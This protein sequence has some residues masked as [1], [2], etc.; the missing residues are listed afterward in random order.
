MPDFR[1]ED[2]HSPDLPV[3]GIDEVGRGP[4][5]GPVVAACVYIPPEIRDMPFIR[6]LQ[7]SKKLTAIKRK[8]LDE[9]IRAHC[10]FAIAECSPAEIDRL[11][12]LQASLKAMADAFYAMPDWLHKHANS[13]VLVDGNFVPKSLQPRGVAIKK[14]DQLS[15][16]IAAA[17]IIAKVYRDA[18]MERLHRA[19]PVYGW[20]RNAGYPTAAHISALQ[21]HGITPHH[22]RSFAPIK[23][24]GASGASGAKHL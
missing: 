11:N 5:A 1:H 22:R 17:S 16:S 20:D 24:S 8:A 3:C 13:K 2:E 23:T 6:A 4:L 15:C 21:E 14:G 12:I 9:S 19:H 18:L 7:D 10:I